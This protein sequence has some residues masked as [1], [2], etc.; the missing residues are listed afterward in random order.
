MSFVCGL[1]AAGCGERQGPVEPTP[2]TEQ[3]GGEQAGEAQPGEQQP[4]EPQTEQN[5]PSEPDKPASGPP[6]VKS[7]CSG[8]ICVEQGNEV[9]SICDFKP[10]YACYKEARCERQPSGQCGWT[11]TPELQSCIQDAR[12]LQ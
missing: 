5:A 6:C 3:T 1:L 9:M 7:G 4:G 12:G 8:I 10:E 2:G 11:E